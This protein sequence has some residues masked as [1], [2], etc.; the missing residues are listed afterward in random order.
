MSQENNLPLRARSPSDCDEHVFADVLIPGKLQLIHPD[1]LLDGND[2]EF[3]ENITPNPLFTA[4]VLK[5]QHAITPSLEYDD[6]DS[7]CPEGYP[8]FPLPFDE[9]C[10][11]D[12]SNFENEK[13]SDLEKA[14]KL[15]KE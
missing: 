8:S 5:R 12:V 6:A 7:I 15:K 9:P 1:N 14:E 4:P 2:L 10:K 11:V 3:S 13:W